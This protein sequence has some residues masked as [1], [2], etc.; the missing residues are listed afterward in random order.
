[1]NMLVQNVDIQ[2]EIINQPVLAIRNIQNVL[3]AATWFLVTKR[4][5]LII[6]HLGHAP[7]AAHQED[8]EK[9][10]PNINKLLHALNAVDRM[11]TKKD[12]A[13][14]MLGQHVLNA[15]ELVGGIRK[16]AQNL[17]ILNHVL[18]VALFVGI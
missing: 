14:I 9:T 3:N 1:M 4:T 11:D 2:E 7:N 15:A 17:S 10:V 8:I 6:C 16:P 5:A 13:N 18:N 12:V